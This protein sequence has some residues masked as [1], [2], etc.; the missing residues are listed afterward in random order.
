MT[1][2]IK[3]ARYPLWL[4]TDMDAILDYVEQSEMCIRDRY[5]GG[6]LEASAKGNRIFL[7]Y[8]EL[9]ADPGNSD[10]IA[11]DPA[12]YGDLAGRTGGDL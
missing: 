4:G 3:A 10:G 9:E 2:L 5:S 11:E 8:L 1:P 7:L 12:G 6:D